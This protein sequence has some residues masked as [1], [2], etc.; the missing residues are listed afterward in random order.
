MTKSSH[1]LHFW[2]PAFDFQTP[3]CLSFSCKARRP[4]DVLQK[5]PIFQD[6]ALFSTRGDML[7]PRESRVYQAKSLGNA[8]N[9][10][11]HCWLWSEGLWLVPEG[12]L[13]CI[14]VPGGAS[15]KRGRLPSS[16]SS[17]LEA[18]GCW[19]LETE[20]EEGEEIFSSSPVLALFS[21]PF[22]PPSTRT[23]GA[24]LEV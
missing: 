4:G 11:W 3:F 23:Q 2:E 18:P 6:R 10:S 9:T 14:Q 20:L 17:C 15:R 22:R 19:F 24:K 12:S 1:C 21:S 8:Y 5:S 16:P 7:R 13:R